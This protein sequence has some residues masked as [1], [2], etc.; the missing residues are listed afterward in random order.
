MGLNGPRAILYWRTFFIF[1]NYGNADVKKGMVSQ[2][3]QSEYTKLLKSL[4]EQRCLNCQGTGIIE[5]V[6]E[7][8]DVNY[9]EISCPVCKGSG[10]DPEKQ[11]STSLDLI[12]EI[13]ELEPTK[14]GQ[15]IDGNN[16][17]D[18]RQ[19]VF[20][21]EYCS[22]Y[23]AKLKHKEDCFISRARQSLNLEKN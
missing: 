5:E 2:M 22:V 15:Y 6:L 10:L 3:Y 14:R 23:D 7:C 19:C 9:R 1:F 12:K 16:I 20:C 8:Q 13:V 11:N 18:M 4:L 21:G 17:A